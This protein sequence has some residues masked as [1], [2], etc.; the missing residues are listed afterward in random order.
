MRDRQYSRSRVV[1]LVHLPSMF[2]FPVAFMAV[3]NELQSTL[4]RSGQEP[5]ASRVPAMDLQPKTSTVSNF[6]Q[7]DSASKL[8][9]S[10]SQF[11]RLL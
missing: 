8:P 9:V 10:P 1:K 11:P 3:P 4:V 2:K 7:F 6:L 5:R